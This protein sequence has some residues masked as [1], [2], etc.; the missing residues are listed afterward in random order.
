MRSGYEDIFDIRWQTFHDA[1]NRL[2]F[3]EPQELA[4][5]STSSCSGHSARLMTLLTSFSSLLQALGLR[6]FLE[7][8]LN[9]VPGRRATAAQM[10][11]H[12]WLR[13]ELPSGGARRGD[14]NSVG[15]SGG[16]GGGGEERRAGHHRH[17]SRS[18][19][20]TPKRSRLVSAP[21][22]PLLLPLLLLLVACHRLPCAAA[23]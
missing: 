17:G 4:A 15:S 22:G 11:Q 6:D 23:A 9:F 19:S 3:S 12:P 16:G 5:C 14:G 7:P 1:T 20:R 10:L 8:M 2:Q 21:C 18:R 13:G